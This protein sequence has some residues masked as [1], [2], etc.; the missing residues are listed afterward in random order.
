[1]REIE[2][3]ERKQEKCLPGC[4]PGRGSRTEKVGHLWDCGPERC[5]QGTLIGSLS[6]GSERST[7][8]SNNKEVIVHNNSS[9]VSPLGFIVCRQVTQQ[10]QHNSY[11]NIYKST[12]INAQKKI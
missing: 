1:M 9:E 2:N 11:Y 10:T 5:N 7:I 3:G 6:Y 4:L 8:L 12:L